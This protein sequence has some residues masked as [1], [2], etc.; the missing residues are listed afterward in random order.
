MGH[1]SWVKLQNYLPGFGGKLILQK[2]FEFDDMP[3]DLLSFTCKSSLI[4][5]LTENEYLLIYMN[6]KILFPKLKR[7]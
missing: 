2:F 6:L 7:S 4:Y 5:R 3:K 1:N